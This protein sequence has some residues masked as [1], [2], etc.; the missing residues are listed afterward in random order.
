MKASPRGT[1]ARTH[2]RAATRDRGPPAA[3]GGGRD[4]HPTTSELTE[5][6][7]AQTC[8]APRSMPRRVRGVDILAWRIKRQCVTAAQSSEVNMRGDENTVCKKSKIR[9]RGRS[10]CRGCRGQEFAIERTFSL[11]PRFNP[12][13]VAAIVSPRATSRTPRSLPRSA[14][15]RTQDRTGTTRSRATRTRFSPS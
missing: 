5:Y 11:S 6:I 10:P 7:F 4:A 3:R 13:L 2:A 15:R 12:R 14:P 8:S 1:G 9:L